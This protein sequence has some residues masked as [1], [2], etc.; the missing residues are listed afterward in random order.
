MHVCVFHLFYFLLL[1][2]PAMHLRY[3]DRNRITTDLALELWL[4]CIC[5]VVFFPL[6]IAVAV[7]LFFIAIAGA[8]QQQPTDK[9]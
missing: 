5:V 2:N 4:Y 8:T 9:N 6:G 1:S 7:V 3:I